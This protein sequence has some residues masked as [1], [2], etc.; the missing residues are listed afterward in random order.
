MNNSQF[1]ILLPQM[2]GIINKIVKSKNAHIRFSGDT[3]HLDRKITISQKNALKRV[4]AAYKAL[5][6]DF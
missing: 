1:I 6:G 4:L 2:K 3:Y 5:G